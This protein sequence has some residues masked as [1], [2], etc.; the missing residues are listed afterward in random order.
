MRRRSVVLLAI[1]A[2]ATAAAYVWQVPLTRLLGR[3]ETRIAPPVAAVPVTAATF[4]RRPMPVR[5]DAIGTVQTIA[6]V[7]L[8]SRVDSTIE[9]VHFADGAAVKEGDILFTLDARA[10][11]AQLKQAEAALERD[12][13]QLEFAQREVARTTSLAARDVV[14]QQNLDTVRTNAAALAATI[15]S[16]EATIENLKV[17]LDYYTVR[18]PIGGRA[19]IVTAKAGNLVSARDAQALVTINQIKPIYVAFAVPQR[20]LAEVRAAEAAGPVAVTATAPGFKAPAEGRLTVIDNT[21]DSATGMIGLRA[22]FDN[23]EAALWPGTT[24]TVRMVLRIEP[25]ALVVPAT[26]IQDGPAGT[27]VF[28]IGD[29]R[30]AVPKP[31]TVARSLDGMAIVASGLAA[32]EQVVTD[33]QLRLIT[34]TPVEIRPAPRPGA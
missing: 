27:L 10:V 32:G 31:V 3:T 4:E 20:F 17:Q 11:E 7:T 15:K 9:A 25:D 30:K 16:D 8:R 5:V 1:L 19:G 28:V 26:A 12:Q 29:D 18:A 24:V 22:S 6:S 2:A 14:S 13:H 34:G 33:G 23:A 21:V